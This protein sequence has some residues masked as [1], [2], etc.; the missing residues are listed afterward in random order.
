MI[1]AAPRRA[2]GAA[3]RQRCRRFCGTRNTSSHHDGTLASYAAARLR[4]F[5]SAMLKH[6]AADAMPD[7][8]GHYFRIAAATIDAS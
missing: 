6:F 5:S 2:V 7:F 8:C 1:A 4:Y 3:R